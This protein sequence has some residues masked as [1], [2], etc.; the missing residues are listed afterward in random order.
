MIE[1]KAGICI[2]AS[3]VFDENIILE[4][5]VKKKNVKKENF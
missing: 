1:V 5:D 3:I 2:W 4:G